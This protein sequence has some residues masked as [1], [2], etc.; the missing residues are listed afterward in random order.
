[1]KNASKP[2]SELNNYFLKPEKDH[3]NK[4][5]RTIHLQRYF[6]SLEILNKFELETSV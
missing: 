2:I 4:H 3:V 6:V 1:M 5:Y